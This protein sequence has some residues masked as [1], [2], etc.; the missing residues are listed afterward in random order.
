MGSTT[1]RSTVS[2][3]PNRSTLAT[4][5]M[6]ASSV[7][8][9]SSAI[10]VRASWDSRSLTT[11]R[12]MMGEASASALTTVMSS[13]PSGSRRSIAATASRMSLAATSRS[14]LGENS[15]RTRALFSSLAAL[16][17]WMPETRA[18][19]PSITLVTSASMVSGE[20]PSKKAR[21]VTIGRSTSGSSRTSTPSKALS[22]A[23]TISRLITTI[24]VGRRTESAGSSLARAITWFRL[25]T[26]GRPRP[27]R[28]RRTAWDRRPG[29]RA[30]P[31]RPP[32]RCGRRPPAAR[33]ARPG[34]RCAAPS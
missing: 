18:T 9:S 10:R 24:S 1:T 19:A 14:T 34:P 11:A 30:G 13:T 3:S 33:R 26:P 25:A 7:A 2:W 22:P 6:A 20:A 17:A 29:P 8:M 23:I 16:I 5:A 28:P 12:R 15:A 31:A 27:G 4:P 21:T 32:P